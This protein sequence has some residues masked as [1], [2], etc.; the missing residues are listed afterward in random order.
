MSTPTTPRTVQMRAHHLA[1]GDVI[2]YEDGRLYRVHR[3]C[4]RVL[5]T[6][7]DRIS[8]EI[9]RSDSFGGWVESLELAFVTNRR[10]LVNVVVDG[11]AA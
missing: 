2:L 7:R 4:V 1:P 3:A 10:S 8:V 9:R 6:H 11:S 5:G